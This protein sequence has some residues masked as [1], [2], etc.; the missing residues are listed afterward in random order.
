VTIT[1]ARHPAGGFRSGLHRLLASFWQRGRI[2]RPLD[3]ARLISAS[4]GLCLLALL[5]VVTPDHL[6]ALAVALPVSR[7]GLFRSVLV[8]VNV[9]VSFVVLGLLL[10]TA[11]D[12]VRFR[13]FA[14]IPGAVA[15][16]AGPALALG[17]ASLAGLGADAAR[18]V[19]LGTP[20]HQS[21][22]LPVAASVAL[23]VGTDLHGSRWWQRARL[24]LAAAVVCALLLGGLSGVSAVF[25]VLTGVTAGLAVRVGLGVVPARP[26]VDTIRAVLA[27]AGW[28]VT[29]LEPVEQAP[30]RVRY[31]GVRAD[32]DDL[33]VTV[34]DPDRRGV[35][36][37]RR[38][39]R[40]LRLRSA[41]VGRP[42]LTF[43]RLLEQQ[44]LSLALAGTA[45][46]AV[47]QLLGL[48]AA[49]PALVL[50]ECPLRGVPLADGGGAT[51]AMRELRR[52]HDAGLAH[53]ALS[54]DT[55]LLLPDGRAGFAHLGSA[56]PAATELQ[57]EL[58][59]VAMLVVLARRSDARTAVAALREGYGT[60]SI[61][62]A[63][64]TALLQP[65]ALPRQTGVRAARR[66]QLL[67]ELRSALS[68]ATPAGTVAAPRLERL[69][70]RTVVSVAAAT[71]AAYLLVGQLSKVDLL[72]ALRDA[73]PGWLAVALLGSAI[74]Y[75]GS[76]LALQ[77]F[78]PIALPLGRTV[79][80]QVASSFV[81]LVTPPAVGQV[82]LNIR[83]L[84]RAGVPTATAAGVV[85]VRE[86]L[87]VLVTVPL[88]LLCGWLSGVSASR[89]TLLPSGDVLLVLAA[90]AAVLA[91]LVAL[92]PTRRLLLGRVQPLLRRT[93]PQLLAAASDPRRL[94][95]GIAGILVLNAGYVLAMDASLRAFSAS[96]PLPT[97]VV[98]YLAA[99]TLG[100]AAPTHG[101]LGAVEAALVGGLTATGVPVAAALP[102]VLAFRTATF[103]LPAPVGWGAM[104]WL[105]RAGRI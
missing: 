27:G 53:G 99:A 67:R 45:G 102:A 5:A 85:A 24:A 69:R 4:V 59:V 39:W 75:L 76:A 34:V 16:L 52:L 93:L 92:G 64:L 86:A 19:L 57:R 88:L 90:V 37:A 3:I 7:A 55:V 95:T 66:R 40:L 26:P 62:E 17:V 100:S 80:V 43:R 91:A 89:L 28:A 61:A 2:R 46:V 77:A 105:Q 9:A 12:A 22:A 15:G 44:A 94:V 103:W 13:R 20:L 25:A 41:A 73:R 78:V 10:A 6:H 63:R 50:V 56:Q 58:D 72:D 49:A 74:T 65:L 1:R 54:G 60:T 8:V 101:G 29:A 82:G 21:A 79:L 51:A 87:T 31:T 42:A 35:P 38:V 68:G 36:F 23:L 18:D 71:L 14:I 11:V 48:L 96:L 104:T 97:L 30:G 84:Q 47:P 83:Y 70:A 98:V 32:G 33:R 81:T